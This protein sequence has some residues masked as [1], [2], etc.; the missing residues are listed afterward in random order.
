MSHFKRLSCLFLCSPPRNPLPSKNLQAYFQTCNGEPSSYIS[1]LCLNY[2]QTSS[3]GA[4]QVQLNSSSR[5]FTWPSMGCIFPTLAQSKEGQI[6]TSD[7]GPK[8]EIHMPRSNHRNQNNT[9]GQNNMSPIKP[10]S[11]KEVISEN[12]LDEPQT[13]N[14]KE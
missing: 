12:Y 14:L 9:N 2:L 13:Q 1:S 10:T 11:P 3:L 5:N 7:I 6:N 4:A 8:K